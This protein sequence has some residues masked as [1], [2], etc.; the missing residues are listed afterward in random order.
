[1]ASDRPVAK[2]YRLFSMAVGSLACG[3]ATGLV[4]LAVLG[5]CLPDSDGA[6]GQ[7]PPHLLSNPFV[8]IVW[9]QVVL[10][11]SGIGFA[12]AIPLLWRV[13][14]D[15]VFPI[16]TCA[17]VTAAALLTPI[18]IALA[19]PGSLA[20]GLF[21]MVLARSRKHWRADTSIRPTA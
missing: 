7:S 18:S 14:L 17:S 15:K 12:C 13:Q 21:V 8:L 1:M 10:Y 16:V 9:G 2:L 5:I 19:V 11:A 20:A 3:V 6:S 4:S